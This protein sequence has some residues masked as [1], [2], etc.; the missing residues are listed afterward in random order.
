MLVLL[1]VQCFACSLRL[2]NVCFCFCLSSQRGES[3]EPVA[4]AAPSVPLSSCIAAAAAA[5]AVNDYLSPA[6]GAKGDAEKTLRLTNYP[7][8]LLVFLK[9]FYISERWIPKKLKCSVEVRQGL[10]FCFRV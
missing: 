10:G 4:A 3:E 8:Y 2:L 7:E 9:R 1:G 6:T 5:A